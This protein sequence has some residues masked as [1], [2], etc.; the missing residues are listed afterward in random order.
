MYGDHSKFRR[1]TIE[2]GEDLSNKYDVWFNNILKIDDKKK[3]MLWAVYPDA[4]KIYESAPTTFDFLTPKEVERIA[5]SK[6][7]DLNDA[8]STLFDVHRIRWIGLNELHYPSELKHIVDPPFALYYEGTGLDHQETCVA[9]V[10]ARE[11]TEYGKKVAYELSYNLAREGLTIVSG[12]AKGI[13]TYAHEGALKAKGKTIAVLGSGLEICYPKENEGL[14][15]RIKNEGVVLSE[16]LPQEKPL[17][18]HF[19]ARNRIISGMSKVVVVVE[20]KQK[21]GS[22]ITAREALEQGRDVGA[23]PG[24]IYS[25]LSTGTNQLIREGAFPILSYIDILNLLN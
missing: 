17:Q 9:I 21:S 12:L 16:Y 24:N 18:Y 14:M 8:I 15:K 20:A 1:S 22:L 13:D 6:A 10:G 4:K 5:L 3:R 23:V 2:S 11:C 25:E 7:G 19:P